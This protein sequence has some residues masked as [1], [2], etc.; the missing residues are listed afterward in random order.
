MI[1]TGIHE[2][3]VIQFV[4]DIVLPETTIIEPMSVI[5]GGAK[6]ALELGERNTIY[7]SCSIRIERGYVKTGQDVSF[8]S[9][10]HIYEPRSGLEIGDYCMIGGGTLI[11]GVEHGFTD[12]DMP[13]RCQAVESRKIVIECDVW[14]GMRVVICPGVTIGQ[15]SVIG[16]GSVVMHDIPPY[17]IAFGTPCKV[18]RKRSSL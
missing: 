4:G 9:G 17:S 8:G 3:V 11:C 7:P 14:I 5:Y 2:S 15:G 16:A 10:C 12:L 13:M 18:E 6:A 1:D